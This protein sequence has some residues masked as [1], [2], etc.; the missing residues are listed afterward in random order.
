MKSAGASLLELP[1]FDDFSSSSLS[2][3]SSLWDDDFAF[4]NN[5]FSIDPVT[6]GVATLD[7]LDA[8]GSIYPGA[9]LSSTFEADFLTSHPINLGYP[10]SDSIYLSFLYQPGGLCNVPEE[11]DSLMVD[12][13]AADSS[14]WINVW[15]IPGTGLH[16]FKQVMIPIT[17]ERFLTSGFRFRFRNWASLPRNNDMPDK[18]SNV[19]YWHLDY[20]RLDRNRF[21]GDTILRDVAFNTPLT[22]VFKEYTAI[23]W[24]HFEQAY[25][26]TLA[27]F[28]SAGYRNNDSIS[29]N[30]TR[31]LTIQEPLYGESEPS[32]TP[33]ALDVPA[34]EKSEV[35]FPLLYDLDYQRGDSALVRLKA[36]LRTDEFDP[37]VNDTVI[38]DQWFRDYYAYD[39]GTPEAGYGLRGDGTAY[40]MVAIRHYSYKPDMLGGV[41]IFFNQVYDSLNL[42]EYTFNLMVWNDAGGIPG[43]VIWDDETIYRPRYTSTYTGF[44][45]YEFSE[46]IPVNGTFYVGW[47]QYKAYILNMGLDLNSVPNTPVML[48]NLGSWLDS[49]A[50][51]MLLFRPYF[52]DSSTGIDR[53]SETEMIP[54]NLYPNPATERIWF[55]FPS[56]YQ[57]NDILLSIYDTSGRQISHSILR[58]NSLDVSEFSPGLYYIRA[59]I[60]GKPYFAKVLINP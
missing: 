47:R 21:A 27:S 18:R 56:G 44:V 42:K 43:S 45:K 19:D 14:E 1:F 5:N 51:G 57:G 6:N 60:A 17:D 26:T 25:N 34:F 10:A 7:A 15:R 28:V 9:E 58:S 59:I 8:S 48:Y 13:Y 2:A 50:P 37:K 29:R 30:V 49:D 32:G 4:V 24:S 33:T 11:E 52:Y 36:A 55:Q 46:P 41:Y 23:P 40:G 38:H 12:F 54:L 3:D 16:P 53:E 31:S 22:S 39:D 20:I 35:H